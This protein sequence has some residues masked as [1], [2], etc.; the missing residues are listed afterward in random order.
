MNQMRNED[1]FAFLVNILIALMLNSIINK[2]NSLQYI[3]FL[4]MLQLQY[5]AN[6]SY[7]TN[8]INYV[9]KIDFLDIDYIGKVLTDKSISDWVNENQKTKIEVNHDILIPNIVE[10]G[11][12]S[13]NPVFNLGGIFMMSMLFLSQ[14]VF[15]A[16]FHIL[17]YKLNMCKYRNY[18]NKVEGQA[19]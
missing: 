9:L 2:F 18:R 19:E 16:V 17:F 1:T 10:Q 5:P 14:I 6:V 11:Y 13:Y 12:E 8:T 4:S 7:L 3:A 15:L